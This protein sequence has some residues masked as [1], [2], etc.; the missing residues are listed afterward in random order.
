MA[1]QRLQVSS[2]EWVEGQPLAQPLALR[3][4]PRAYW[5]APLSDSV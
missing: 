3:E 5:R 2:P 1:V 4:V